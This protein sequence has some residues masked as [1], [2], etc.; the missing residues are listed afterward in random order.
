M[1]LAEVAKSRGLAGVLPSPALITASLWRTP[2][3]LWCRW[4]I[5]GPGLILP[6]E[7]AATGVCALKLKNAPGPI[8]F[9]QFC[10]CRACVRSSVRE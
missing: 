10:R 4:E 1:R 3:V 8:R 9:T 5:H 7:S 2:V 6:H